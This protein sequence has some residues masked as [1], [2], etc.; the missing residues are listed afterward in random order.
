MGAPGFPQGTEVGGEQ[1]T[2]KKQ[3]PV[4]PQRME[5]PEG[6]VAFMPH[7]GDNASPAVLRAPGR[8][9][10]DAELRY[11]CKTTN[12]TRNFLL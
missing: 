5:G 1:G 9:N 8:G 4:T 10:A 6:H 2:A 12:G 3:A 11:S 7:L